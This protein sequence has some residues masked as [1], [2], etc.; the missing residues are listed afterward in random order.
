MC[1]VVELGWGG[2]HNSP[3]GAWGPDLS[4]PPTTPQPPV[5]LRPGFLWP[6]WHSVWPGSG[7]EQPACLPLPA[8]PPPPPPETKDKAGTQP[9]TPRFLFITPSFPSS[10]SRLSFSPQSLGVVLSPFFSSFFYLS[11]HPVFFF[12]SVLSHHCHSIYHLM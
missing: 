3:L 8:P 7:P 9:D 2:G 4:P 1:Q 12:P 11:H 10:L 6:A 5:P